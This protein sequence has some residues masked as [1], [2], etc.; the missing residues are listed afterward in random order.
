MEMHVSDTFSRA[1]DYA[2]GCTASRFR[3]PLWRVTELLTGRRFRFAI[4]IVKQ[5]GSRIVA[6]A[7]Q[8][9]ESRESQGECVIDSNSGSLINSLLD[10]IED[11]QLVADAALNYLSAGPQAPNN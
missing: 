4:R 1:F 10:A 9:R 11:R 7:I 8:A 6:N 2:S 3:N 5:F